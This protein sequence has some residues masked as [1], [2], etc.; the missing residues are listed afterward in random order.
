MAGGS[1]VFGEAGEPGLEEQ[2][3]HHGKVLGRLP[4]LTGTHTDTVL[5]ITNVG[6]GRC[7]ENRGYHC[8]SGNKPHLPCCHSPPKWNLGGPASSHLW[9]QIQWAARAF[10]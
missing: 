9:A 4:P 7:Q 5:C 10:D 2:G 1:W 8:S 3:L 6:L